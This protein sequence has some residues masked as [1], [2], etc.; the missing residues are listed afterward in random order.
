MGEAGQLRL[1]L[2]GFVKSRLGL[3][4]SG[5]AWC[6]KLR[7]VKAGGVWSFMSGRGRV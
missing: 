7:L 6:G 3:V 2:L 5:S 1:G 4:R